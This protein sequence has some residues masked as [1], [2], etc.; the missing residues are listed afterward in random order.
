MGWLHATASGTP[1]SSSG[2]GGGATATATRS[3]SVSARS[4]ARRHIMAAPERSVEGRLSDAKKILAVRRGS[5]LPRLKTLK[6]HA[7]LERCA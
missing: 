4:A 3:A 7:A 1:E 6:R 2:Q 5:K